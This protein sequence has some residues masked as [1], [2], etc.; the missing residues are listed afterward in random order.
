MNTD[1]AFNIY[2]LLPSHHHHYLSLS[3]KCKVILKFKITILIFKITVFGWSDLWSSRLHFLIDLLLTFKITK[4]WWSCPSLV[5]NLHFALLHI[6][7]KRILTYHSICKSCQLI[8]GIRYI[9]CKPPFTRVT[10]GGA[11]LSG[12][13]GSCSCRCSEKL[14]QKNV[15][16]ITVRSR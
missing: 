2:S 16:Y 4:R 1:T 3:T 12:C 13:S 10:I 15:I 9:V 8:N 6:W 7:C 11:G 5:A 14:K